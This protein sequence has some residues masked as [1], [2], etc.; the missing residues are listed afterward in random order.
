ML[1]L[2]NE[3]GITVNEL[4]TGEVIEMKDYNK[5]AEENLLDMKRQKEEADKRLLSLEIALG[6]ISSISFLILI[7]IASYIEMPNIVRISLITVGIVVFSIGMIFCLKIEQSAGYY[8][9]EKCHHKYIPTYKDV[10]M[11]MHFG[12]TRYLRCQKCNQKSWN[13]KVITKE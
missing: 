9:C 6:Y 1:D 7:F 4:L 12:R 2:C 3:L 13:K 11:A 10:F 8:E 5:K